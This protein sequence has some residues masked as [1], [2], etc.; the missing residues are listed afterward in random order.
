MSVRNQHNSMAW[1]PMPRAPF[2]GVS[3]LKFGAYHGEAGL[4]NWRN[5][6]DRSWARLLSRNLKAFML[7]NQKVSS[8][9]IR[10]GNP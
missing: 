10:F 4:Q 1:L 6:W 7:E 3:C 8:I 9:E 2:M 5:D